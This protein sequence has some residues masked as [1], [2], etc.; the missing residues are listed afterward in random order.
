MEIKDQREVICKSEDCNEVITQIKDKYYKWSINTYCKECKSK[1][2]LKTKGQK[3]IEDK[4]KGEVFSMYASDKSARSGIQYD[5]KRRYDLKDRPKKCK[6]CGYDK[7]YF[8]THI[9]PVNDFKPEVP[10]KVINS[11][12]NTLALCKNCDTEMKKNLKSSKPCTP[13]PAINMTKDEFYSQKKTRTYLRTVLATH[14]RKT[15]L[16]SGKP[17]ICSNCGYSKYIEVAHIK[18]V[19]DFPGDTQIKEINHP[20][21]L[22]GLCGN[23]HYAVDKGIIEIAGMTKS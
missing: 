10:I 12:S 16:S 9:K 22:K 13:P 1:Q 2:T 19:K 20:T 15:F 3:T 23:C 17:A 14:A 11:E 18:A 4:T 5:A 8:V 7:F 21:N 6:I